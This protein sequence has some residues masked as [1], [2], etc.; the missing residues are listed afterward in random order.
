MAV[1]RLIQKQTRLFLTQPSTI[2]YPLKDS[3]K[4]LFRKKK[5]FQMQFFNPFKVSFGLLSAF[6]LIYYFH[7]FF[8]FCTLRHP[9][10]SVPGDCDFLVY[11]ATLYTLYINIYVCIYIYGKLL[12]KLWIWKVIYKGNMLQRL[13]WTF[14][15]YYVSIK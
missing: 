7:F 1:F 6:V 13:K 14:F 8:L 11:S 2:F 12:I 3:E 5:N 15:L 9:R 4:P 10:F